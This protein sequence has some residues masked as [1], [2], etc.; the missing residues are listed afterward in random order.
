MGIKGGVK[1][2]FFDEEIKIGKIYIDSLKRALEENFNTQNILERFKSE[3]D[4]NITFNDDAEIIPIY[5]KNY[6]KN[7]LVSEFMQL[8]DVV[9]GAIRTQKLK[10][11]SFPIRYEI[12]KPF[13]DLLEKEME[14]LP[15]MQ[16]SRYYKGFALSDTWIEDNKWKFENMNT[17]VKEDECQ[18]LPFDKSS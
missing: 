13:K 12:T 16:N 5:K 9:I 10:M 4:E 15:R 2:L 6:K 18:N 3:A 1:F 14:N 17:N 8:A 7:D 11:R